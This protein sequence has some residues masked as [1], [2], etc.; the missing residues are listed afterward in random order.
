MTDPKYL[1]VG[2]HADT[3]SGGA[4]ARDEGKGGVPVAPGDPVSAAIV[5]PNDPHD[6]HLIEDG[7][8]IEPV[9]EKKEA[10]R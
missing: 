7:L 10:K 1:Y 9:Q 3:V 8:L 6:R 2:P 5:D 4:T